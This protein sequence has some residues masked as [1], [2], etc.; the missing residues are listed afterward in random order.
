MATNT[1]DTDHMVATCG[2]H[3]IL[4]YLLHTCCGTCA[5][6]GHRMVVTGKHLEQGKRKK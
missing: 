1:V 5:K 2:H 6:R 3:D 4:G